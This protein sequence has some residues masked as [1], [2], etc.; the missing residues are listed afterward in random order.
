[1]M[2]FVYTDTY[3]HKYSIHIHRQKTTATA[4]ADDK[5]IRCGCR[6]RWLNCLQVVFVLVAEYVY[7]LK[8]KTDPSWPSNWP[9]DQKDTTDTTDTEYSA[10]VCRHW[11]LWSTY[12]YSIY[13]HYI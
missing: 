9:S 2:L 8:R 10:P 6:C 11:F 3:K 4:T 1:M 7:R 5:P 12:K 13:S